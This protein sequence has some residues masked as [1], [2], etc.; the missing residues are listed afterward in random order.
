MGRFS[1]AENL[2]KSIRSNAED[3]INQQTK[4]K[5]KLETYIETSY[6]A[7]VKTKIRA[8]F[9]LLPITCSGQW[10]WG[11]FT[12]II[13]YHYQS[14]L[15]FLLLRD[16]WQV[17]MMQRFSHPIW[18]CYFFI[19]LTLVFFQ[20]MVQPVWLFEQSPAL[21]QLNC[22]KIK[23]SFCTIISELCSL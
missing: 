20:R 6:Q 19:L 15:S 14:N 3:I 8:F 16:A 12:S 22:C 10:V 18:C 13:N 23:N 4:V 11:Y 2:R 7:A 21:R 1:H 5:V 9:V 17:H